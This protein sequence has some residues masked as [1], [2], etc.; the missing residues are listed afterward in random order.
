MAGTVSCAPAVVNSFSEKV[1][2][3]VVSTNGSVGP[4]AGFGK[5]KVH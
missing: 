2:D 5:Q 4:I 1:R 3:R